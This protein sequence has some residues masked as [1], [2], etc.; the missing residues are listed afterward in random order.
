MRAGY[1][2][3]Q[4]IWTPADNDS[5]KSRDKSAKIFPSKGGF[6]SFIAEVKD[7]SK[8]DQSIITVTALNEIKE[9]VDSMP[10][11]SAM[12][13]DTKVAWKDLCTKFG[14]SCIVPK[15]LLTFGYDA[16]LKWK[17]DAYA[18]DGDLL[19]AVQVGKKNN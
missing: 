6:I 1:E 13:N 10:E 9:Y 11:A 18:S 15:S 14:D 19:K 7:P 2:D 8:D 3:E 16:Q 4:V 17:K 12:I 5:L